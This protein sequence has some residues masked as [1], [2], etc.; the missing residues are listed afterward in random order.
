MVA[1]RT[2]APGPEYQSRRSAPWRSIER[3]AGLPAVVNATE[4]GLSMSRFA[5]PE[6]D[7]RLSTIRLERS[8]NRIS[9]GSS[10]PV[11]MPEVL[12][13]WEKPISTNIQSPD[14]RLMSASVAAVKVLTDPSA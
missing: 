14:Q 12:R 2:E 3:G 13:A 11:A 10:A 1:R 9:S 7:R 8:L 6:P 4:R 5:G